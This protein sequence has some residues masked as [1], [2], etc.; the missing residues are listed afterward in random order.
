MRTIFTIFKKEMTDTLRDRRTVI[1]M[2]LIPFLLIPFIF[3][4]SVFVTSSQTET[5]KDKQLK[6][7][8]YSNENGAELV[9]WLKRRK[10]M[11]VLD[12]VHPQDFKKLIRNDSLDFAVLIDDGFDEAIDGG[13]TGE[14]D[15]YYKSLSTPFFTKD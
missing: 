12:N 9:K 7:A 11:E 4:I 8:V 1:T 10:D 15:I 5:A 6:I 14:I 13:V 2:V 3:T